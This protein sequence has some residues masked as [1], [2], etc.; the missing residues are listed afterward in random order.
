MSSAFSFDFLEPTSDFQTPITFLLLDNNTKC[1]FSFSLLDRKENFGNKIV[2]ICWKFHF[3]YS[4]SCGFSFGGHGT[5]CNVMC[6]SGGGGGG[7]GVLE[8]SQKYRVS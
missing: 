1:G 8:K 5:L 6:G 3:P 2:Q 4:C 7:G